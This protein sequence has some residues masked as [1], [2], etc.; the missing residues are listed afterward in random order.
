M[1]LPVWWSRR[2]MRHAPSEAVR[3]YAESFA[4]APA[5]T[6]WRE[7][8]FVVFDTEATGLDVQA[9][10]LLSIAAV[11][12]RGDVVVLRDSFECVVAGDRVGAEAASVHGLVPRDL[13]GGAEEDRAALAFLR[14]AGASILVAHHAAFDV[15]M[16]DRCLAPGGGRLLNAVLD[17]E[18]LA[19][20]LRAG[21][22]PGRMAQ[23]PRVS[24]DALAERYALD[25]PARHTAAG[26]ALL[27]A[28]ALQRLL[29]GA[30][31]R[32]LRT[33]G[34]LLRR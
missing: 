20:R 27:T 30:E 17:T 8:H 24:L 6:P 9:D 7:A 32:G 1:G 3:A 18:R 2:R 11:R 25:T 4:P 15:A 13:D 5:S 16:L 21:G 34:D 26:D 19:R 10:R 29:R 12:M 22:S 23:E 14:Y 28:L 33:V 31:A